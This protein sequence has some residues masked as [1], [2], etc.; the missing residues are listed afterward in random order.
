MSAASKELQ[1]VDIQVRV[2]MG[3][4]PVSAT[5]PPSETDGSGTTSDRSGMS[6]YSECALIGHRPANLLLGSCGFT[7]FFESAF[8]ALRAAFRVRARLRPV[9]SLGRET[10]PESD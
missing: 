1:R 5:G 6:R 3:K 9:F 2:F 4:A 7:A 8:G 10:L